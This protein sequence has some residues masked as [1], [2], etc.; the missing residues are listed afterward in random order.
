M[1]PTLIFSQDWGKTVLNFQE[2]LRIL[3]H[4]HTFKKF[5]QIINMKLII[6]NH[7]VTTAFCKFPWIWGNFRILH[8]YFF[9]M[10]KLHKQV[11]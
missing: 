4:I 8:E 9:Y 2:T 11:A 1:Y 10:N 7:F 6:I 3:P 5:V